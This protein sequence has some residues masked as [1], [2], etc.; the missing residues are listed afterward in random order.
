[1]GFLLGP[2][3]PGA[4]EGAAPVPYFHPYPPF[5]MYPQVEAGKG[6]TNGVNVVGTNEVNGNGASAD[7]GEGAAN[8]DAEGADS[9][10]DQGGYA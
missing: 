8:K 3:P 2:P 6:K 5:G 4:E 10:G 7:A 1:M 9:D